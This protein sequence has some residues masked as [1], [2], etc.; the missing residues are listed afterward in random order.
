[1]KR[2]KASAFTILA[3]LLATATLTS[4]SR[5]DD[6][7]TKTGLLTCHAA[8]GFG[9][10]IASS[11]TLE[12]EYVPSQGPA[13]RYQGTI[14]KIGIDLGY[15]API[16]LIW[17][18]IAPSTVPS[19]GALAGNYFGATAQVA[20]ALGGGVSI[21]TGGFRKSIAL[22][23]VTLEGDAGLYIGVG[24]ASMSLQVEER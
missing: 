19:N 23:P 2:R 16:A 15:L 18:V 11:R 7:T 21:L 1:M 12:C 3:A 20:V 17:G 8:S 6:Y 22:Q 5:A 4:T 9:W 10:I 13:E 14:T 24:F